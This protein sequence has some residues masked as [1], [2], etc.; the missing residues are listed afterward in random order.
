MG[1][2]KLL[3]VMV[4]VVSVVTPVLIAVAVFVQI[5]IPQSVKD[6]IYPQVIQIAVVTVVIFL[7]AQFFLSYRVEDAVDRR[8]SAIKEAVISI[9]KGEELKS[10]IGD[11][12]TVQNAQEL[13]GE[14]D[15]WEKATEKGIAK[16]RK[17][18]ISVFRLTGEPD[19]YFNPNSF[20]KLY[21]RNRMIVRL[22]NL[23]QIISILA[24]G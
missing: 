9:G 19:L 5:F 11:F 12:W 8:E 3:W 21:L 20:E 2:L 15:A 6:A 24:R 13:L 16:Y 4:R 18:I 14:V 23:S 22:R 10:K 7:L 17:E 1:M